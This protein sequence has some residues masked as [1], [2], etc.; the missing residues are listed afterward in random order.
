[1]TKRRFDLR[2]A[3]AIAACLAVTTVFSGCEKE[4]GNAASCGCEN[5]NIVL[6]SVSFMSDQTWTVGNQIWSAPVVISYC[7][8][9]DY[10]GGERTDYGNYKSDGRNNSRQGYSQLFSWCLVKQYASQIAK[11]GWRIP[12]QE[13]FKTLYYAVGC[14]NDALIFEDVYKE[15][16]ANVMKMNY[17]W[18]P[19]YSGM[20]WFNEEPTQQGRYDVCWSINEGSNRYSAITM[21]I[22]PDG[23]YSVVEVSWKQE[24]YKANAASLRLVRDK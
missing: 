13:D 3:V 15:E 16:R 19:S 4:N 8:K 7:D 23:G 14:S 2:N 22:C 10:Y 1:M 21:N 5:S 18:S 17:A 9:D 20:L 11:D 6:G 24:H 12:T